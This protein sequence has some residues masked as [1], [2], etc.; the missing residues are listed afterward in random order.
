MKKISNLI[1][2]LLFDIDR[3]KYFFIRRMEFFHTRISLLAMIYI[4]VPMRF[5]NHL[6]GR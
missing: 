2:H 6:M 5:F 3:L 1:G 4:L